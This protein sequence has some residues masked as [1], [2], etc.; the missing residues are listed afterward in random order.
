MRPIFRPSA[1]ERERW[2]SRVGFDSVDVSGAPGFGLY[3][4]LRLFFVLV[5]G[6]ADEVV[7]L[8]FVFAEAVATVAVGIVAGGFDA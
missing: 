3:V 6:D 4:A 8:S 1:R 5:V 2:P 7:V